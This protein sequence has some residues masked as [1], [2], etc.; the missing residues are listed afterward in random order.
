MQ[1]E[2]EEEKSSCVGEKKKTRKRGARNEGNGLLRQKEGMKFWGAKMKKQ[3]EREKREGERLLNFSQG[4]F[5]SEGT[6]QILMQESSVGIGKT[7]EISMYF[8]GSTQ[9]SV[10]KKNSCLR[11]IN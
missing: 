2:K 8:C 9:V 4:I 10:Q 3:S 1:R 11:K 6:V 7:V 5:C